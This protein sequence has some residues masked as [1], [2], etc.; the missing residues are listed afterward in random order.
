MAFAM[1]TFGRVTVQA[2]TSLTPVE[3]RQL[4]V[5]LIRSAEHAED[6]LTGAVP[7]TVLFSTEDGSYV[8]TTGAYPSLSWIADNE[9]DAEMGLRHLMASEGLS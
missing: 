8:A 4:A 7:V 6:Y 2:D 1:H 3:A 9:A 5:E